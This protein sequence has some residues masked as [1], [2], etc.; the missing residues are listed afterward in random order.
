M[1]RK[2]EK[3]DAEIAHLRKE[4]LTYKAIGQRFNISAGRAAIIVQREQRRSAFIGA[5]PVH[6]ALGIR[7]LN[8]LKNE[9]VNPEN[10]NEIC[11][12]TAAYLLR[13]P[14]FGL[15]SLK[16]LETYLAANGR[17]LGDMEPAF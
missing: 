17:R 1:A 6:S 2:N 7:T 15:K 8:C 16:E 11:A 10:I 14:N 13:N 12:H 5:H 9:G 3:R 4:G